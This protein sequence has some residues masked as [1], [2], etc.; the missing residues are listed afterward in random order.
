MS[1]IGSGP[2][3]S[4]FG[5]TSCL[6]A[7][8]PNETGPLDLTRRRLADGRDAKI[9]AWLG[10]DSRF[11]SITAPARSPATSWGPRSAPTS[12]HTAPAAA[13]AGASGSVIANAALAP[14]SLCEKRP[15]LRSRAL[16]RLY[17]GHRASAK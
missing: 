10:D 4:S 12:T 2:S 5:F 8:Q 11:L 16:L 7:A 9:L 6:M 13:S 1:V 17:G 15:C 14:D 3:C